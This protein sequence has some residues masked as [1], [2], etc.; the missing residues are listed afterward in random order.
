MAKCITCE[1]E[2]D[3]KETIKKHEVDFCSEECLKKYEEKLKELE[4][5]VDWDN[6]CQYEFI[7][8]L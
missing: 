3:P 5:V 4:G 8:R 7:K 2:V 6:C 1:K